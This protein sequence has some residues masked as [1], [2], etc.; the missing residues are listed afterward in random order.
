MLLFAK[1]VLLMTIRGRWFMRRVRTLVVDG[2]LVAVLANI[3]RAHGTCNELIGAGRALAACFGMITSGC[4]LFCAAWVTYK[5]TPKR[6]GSRRLAAD[7]ATTNVG[8]IS[9]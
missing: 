3:A 2:V 8:L 9:R 1:W 7:C 4:S 6:T 5:I